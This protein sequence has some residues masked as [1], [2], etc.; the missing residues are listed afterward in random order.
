MTLPTKDQNYILIDPKSPLGEK[1]LFKIIRVTKNDNEVLNLETIGIKGSRDDH[2]EHVSIKSEVDFKSIE[3]MLK[4]FA[5]YDFT[6]LTEQ[7]A[8]V[9][10]L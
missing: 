5:T 8:F 6:F 7:E 9:E 2:W 1:A 10:I 3:D 4:A